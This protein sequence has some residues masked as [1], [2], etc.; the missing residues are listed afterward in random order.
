MPRAK[1]IKTF[2]GDFETTIY[3]KQTETEV[4]ASAIVELYS[5]DVKIFHSI[6]DTFDWILGQRV[7]CKIYYH[8][9]KFDGSFWVDFLMKAGYTLAFDESYKEKTWQKQKFMKNGTFYP[10][11]SDMGQW[12]MINIKKYGHI[13][14]L[15]DSLKLLPL[16]VEQ[17]GKSFKTKHQKLN[18]EYV[19]FRYAG[20]KITDKEKEYIANDVLVVKEALELMF[21]QGHQ[22][23]TIGSCC[24][25]EFKRL[26]GISEITSLPW[27][28][29][30]PNLYE[31]PAPEGCGSPTVGHYILRSY[32]GAWTYLVPER[33]EK[34][35]KN[36]LTADVNSLYPS[37]MHSESGNRYPYGL[38]I[39]W[40]GAIPEICKKD[41]IYYF[42]RIKTRFYLKDG[43][44]PCIQI[45]GNPFYI[46]KEWLTTSDI[47]DYETE[48]YFSHIEDIDTR[49]TLTLTKTDYQLI[50]EHYDLVD[51]EILDG[52]YFKTIL[53]IFDEYI[54]KYKQIKMTTKGGERQI[55]KFYLVNLYGKMAS[56][57]NSSFK[58][59]ILGEDGVVHF[60]IQ[61]EHDKKPG[62]IPVGSAITSYAR[63]FTIHT[64]QANFHGPD[65]P[66]FIYADTDS[67]HCDCRPEDLVNV[68]IDDNDFCHW[69]LESYW[70]VGYF[71]RQKCYYEH[72]THEN[73][74]P[75]ENP[76]DNLTAAGMTKK[77]KQNFLKSMRK[78]VILEKLDKE[79]HDFFYDENGDRIIRAISDLKTGLIVPGK[80]RPKRIPGG[81]ILEKTSFEINLPKKKKWKR[82][83]LEKL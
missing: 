56:N 69:K 40:Q 36:G 62:Y 66:G 34:I 59:P 3:P 79:E 19:G 12:Y 49:V 41:E 63:N 71:L 45:K 7:D 38:P 74:K 31:V 25:E 70:D 10:M 17:I 29:L 33:A 55:A 39:F 52:C 67:I 61:E 27:D 78:G 73:G 26:I 68:P 46:G 2:V 22:K 77:C 81:V 42:V 6:E 43:M 51:L 64:A 37:V 23:M 54:D 15:I 16:S 18:M 76:V 35:I 21:S 75:L 58:F 53:G 82:E 9:L 80:L 1:Q 47:Y 20:C 4:W 32:K 13:I 50:K 24:L 83:E 72:Q 48:T 60:G 28:E 8:N 44:L 5:E 57:D 14:Q 30:F 11:I 65:K